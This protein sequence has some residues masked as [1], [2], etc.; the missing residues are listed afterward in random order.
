MKP[1]PG[2]TVLVIDDE[3]GPRESLRLILKDSYTVF[4]A[5]GGDEG[6]SVLRKNQIDIVILDLRMPG[7]TGLETL[8]EIRSIDTEIPVIIL[9]GYGTI[10]DAR[11][12][13]HHRVF[14]FLAKPFDIPVMKD[15]IN[16]AVENRRM[17]ELTRLELRKGQLLE[18]IKNISATSP[19][20]ET[21]LNSV[22]Q[23]AVIGLKAETAS[24]F[25]YEEPTGELVLAAS[26]GVPGGIEKNTR[27]A[28]EGNSITGWM[29]R[30]GTPLILSGNLTDDTLFKSVNS[31][32]SS[33][34]S[35]PL[36]SGDE[37]LGVIH[38]SNRIKKTPF[39]DDDLALFSSIARQIALTVKNLRLQQQLIKI[40]KQLI[41]QERI[42][43]LAELS[44]GIAHE[45]ATPLNAIY[46]LAE[47]AKNRIETPMDAMEK[48]EEQTLRASR[49]IDG[50]KRLSKQKPP[51]AKPVSINM[52]LE[53]TISLLNYRMLKENVKVRRY[54]C[55][56]LPAVF[57]DEIQLQQ[58]FIN[59]LNNA[60]DALS[61]NREITVT[62]KSEDGD[63]ITS[64]TDRGD[65]IRPE[66]ISRIFNSFFTTKKDGT[67]LGLSIVK[68]L[69]EANS[70]RIHVSSEAGKQ[71]TFTITFP[72][73]SQAP[74][75]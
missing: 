50:L 51:E 41:I 33:A 1:V 59:L 65:G 13:T 66:D 21:S 24:I 30:T 8:E 15:I 20:M 42:V 18:E 22:L 72:S 34:L 35:G 43:S 36:K 46:G 49:I 2:G 31:G 74:A 29:A 54:L 68:N 62:T 55:N 5:S 17:Q 37:I 39:S 27:H 11:Q 48:I 64:I 45:L 19:D 12:A 7:K 4:T 61:D 44:A 38:V 26:H 53:T 28:L 25:L 69:V 9:T 75:F 70:G 32:I 56:A 73:Y 63:V 3:L 60:L 47:L 58:I 57:V 6:L 67:G 10:E 52:I 14:E 23:T 40:Q 71:T 16:R